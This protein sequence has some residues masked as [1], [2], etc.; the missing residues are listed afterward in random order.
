MINFPSEPEDFAWLVGILEGEGTFYIS[1]M[2]SPA[3]S[4][5]RYWLPRIRVKMTDS[6]VIT[7]VHR[8]AGIGRLNG[9]YTYGDR[10]PFWQWEV[11]NKS[12]AQKFLSRVKP[13]LSTRRQEQAQA[14]LDQLLSDSVFVN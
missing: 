8:I 9:P 14:V 2:G 11:T 7:R 5:Q 1:Q 6:D 12:D 4:G 10:K 3:L 13:Y